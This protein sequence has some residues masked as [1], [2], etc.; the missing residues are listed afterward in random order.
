MD[1]K[2]EI[3]FERLKKIQNDRKEKTEA[4]TKQLYQWVLT[5]DGWVKEPRHS[6]PD[7]SLTDPYFNRQHLINFNDFDES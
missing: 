1:A 7:S 3:D 6:R 2:P 4:S 5:Q